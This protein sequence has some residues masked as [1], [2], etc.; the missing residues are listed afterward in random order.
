MGDVAAATA[1][2]EQVNKTQAARHQI[3]D[4]IKTLMPYKDN[5][6]SSEFK[7]LEYLQSQS[8][9]IGKVAELCLVWSTSTFVVEADEARRTVEHHIHTLML[10][11]LKTMEQACLKVVTLPLEVFRELWQR[12]ER[13]MYE[14]PG[15]CLAGVGVMSAYAYALALPNSTAVGGFLSSHALVHLNLSAV[16]S[17]GGSAL[18]GLV[19]G[20]II[21]GSIHLYQTWSAD[22]DVQVRAGLEAKL[23]ELK[24]NTL[25]A[26]AVSE[27]QVFF[28]KAYVEPLDDATVRATDGPQRGGGEPQSCSIM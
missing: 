23:Q 16:I 4:Q 28:D 8:S 24:S 12:A 1:L 18:I 7:K 20:A 13:L 19:V 3:E 2:L 25:S 9:A 22:E 14:H 26:E 17:S 21:L 5:K 6:D 27:V 15:K 11:I 10:G